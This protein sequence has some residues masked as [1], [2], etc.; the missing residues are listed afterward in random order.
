MSKA[1]MFILL[2]LLIGCTENNPMGI[3]DA[4]TVYLS[5]TQNG[6]ATKISCEGVLVSYLQYQGERD[7]IRVPD[8][9][10]LKARI[11]DGGDFIYKTEKAKNGLNWILP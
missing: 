10:E 2:V 4:V 1:I 7:T 9:S 11:Y 5:L 8:G 3:E 6:S